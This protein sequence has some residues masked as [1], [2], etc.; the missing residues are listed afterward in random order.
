MVAR[1]MSQP[2][3]Q[4]A[5]VSSYPP[6]AKMIALSWTLHRTK[7]LFSTVYPPVQGSVLALEWGNSWKKE[8]WILQRERKGKKTTDSAFGNLRG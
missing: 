5:G 1:L 2:R 3:T 8:A 6:P 7:S 4:D